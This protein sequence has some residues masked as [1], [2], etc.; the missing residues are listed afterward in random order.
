VRPP[1]TP[2]KPRPAPAVARAP[3]P[4]VAVER[5]VWHPDA[6]RRRA[7]VRLGDRASTEL[8]EG[9]SLGGVAVRRIEPSGVVFLVEGRELRR[10]VGALP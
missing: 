6:T 1:P 9:D 8:R 3:E 4:K 10:A 5:T 2:P 7:W